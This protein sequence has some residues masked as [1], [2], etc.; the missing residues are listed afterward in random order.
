[1]QG[2]PTATSDTFMFEIMQENVIRVSA[3][4]PQDAA[5]GVAPGAGA[6][7]RVPEIPD[8]EFPGTVTRIADVGA[9][10]LSWVTAGR[11]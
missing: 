11:R 8:R 3:Y 10:F 2:P 6:V 7:V 5:F 9:A 1:V 4:V